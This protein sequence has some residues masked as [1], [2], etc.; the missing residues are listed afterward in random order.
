MK[1]LVEFCEEHGPKFADKLLDFE[2]VDCELLKYFYDLSMSSMKD[3]TYPHKILFNKFSEVVHVAQEAFAYLVFENYYNRWI[4]QAIKKRSND[5][6]LMEP[7]TNPNVPNVLYQKNVKQRKDNI[8]SAG[9]WTNEG[10]NRLNELIVKVQEVRED[11]EEFE[12]KLQKL[13]IESEPSGQ[14]NQKMNQ[15]ERCDKEKD[16][17]KKRRVEVINVLKVEEL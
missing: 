8:D 7:L 12:L 14:Y 1:K 15:R 4:Y 5:R 17:R 6:P 2:N 3:Y 11:R 16:K 10:M 9:K 13:Y